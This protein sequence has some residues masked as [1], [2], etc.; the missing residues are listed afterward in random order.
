MDR[1]LNFLSDYCV[2]LT[3][4]ELSE[5][6][7]HDVKRRVIDTLGCAMGSYNM[8]PPMIARA[9]ALEVVSTP[10]ATVLGTRHRRNWR[11]LQTGLCRV[12]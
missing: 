9:H 12:T 1:I 11:R 2:K 10:G 8:G 4:Q 7:V 3:Y 5:S 6:V